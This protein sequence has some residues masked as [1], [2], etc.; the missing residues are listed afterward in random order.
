[1]LFLPI[2][3]MSL[4]ILSHQGCMGICETVYCSSQF[5]TLHV[6]LFSLK[7][8]EQVVVSKFYEPNE[9]RPF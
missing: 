5:L 8:T 4:S 2:F 3:A 9:W 6:F 1:M 7:D